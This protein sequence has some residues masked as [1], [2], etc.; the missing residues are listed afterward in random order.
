MMLNLTLN[1]SFQISNPTT[2]PYKIDSY[3]VQ[4]TLTSQFEL[5][6]KEKCVVNFFDSGLLWLTSRKNPFNESAE[7]KHTLL[8]GR[9][10][11]AAEGYAA[12]ASQAIL[13]NI[14]MIREIKLNL[15]NYFYIQVFFISV[16]YFSL[17]II[18]SCL[19]FCTSALIEEPPLKFVLFHYS[20]TYG[21]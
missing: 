7:Q 20:F 10:F 3:L 6:F 21:T 11:Q 12:V 5:L 16:K 18:F 17:K 13:K 9:P 4:L 14:K 8:H 1:V 15:E 2:L 19:A